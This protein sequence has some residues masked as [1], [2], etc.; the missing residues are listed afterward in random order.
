MFI[1][2]SVARTYLHLLYVYNNA[3]VGK[4]VGRLARKSIKM[5]KMTDVSNVVKTFHRK[6]YIV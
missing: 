2:L 4:S 1:K 5:K 3:E 6:I